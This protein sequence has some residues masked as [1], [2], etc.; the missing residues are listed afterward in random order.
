MNSRRR[1][2]SPDNTGTSRALPAG[3]AK[4]R[5]KHKRS[6]KKP[7]TDGPEPEALIDQFP[8]ALGFSAPYDQSTYSNAA[9]K[10]RQ[11]MRRRSGS[12]EDAHEALLQLFTI[13]SSRGANID[14][15]F[16]SSLGGLGECK[17]IN[18]R[19]WNKAVIRPCPDVCPALILLPIPSS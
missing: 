13:S 9:S 12:Q 15:A 8:L 11:K 19:K 2:R 5:R 4:K 6:R 18:C 3:S 16:M 1:T 10:V 14:Q 17:K 7:R